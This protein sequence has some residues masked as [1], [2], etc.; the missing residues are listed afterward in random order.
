MRA[1]GS[2]ALGLLYKL[3]IFHPTFD[4]SLIILLRIMISNFLIEYGDRPDF[5]IQGLRCELLIDQ[6]SKS[7][8]VLEYN[9]L[10][11]YRYDSVLTM[12]EE[13]SDLV[14]YITPLVLRIKIETVLMDRNTPVSLENS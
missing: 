4:A 13:A 2:D 1:K 11:D 6:N 14:C 9:N 5:D 7:S 12:A 8:S 10:T 3:V